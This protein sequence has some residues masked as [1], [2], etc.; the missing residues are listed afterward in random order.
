MSPKLFFQQLNA[1]TDNLIDMF[2]DDA[3]FPTFKTFVGM[4]QT[5]NPALVI[6]SYH[7][8]VGIPYKN[9]IEA[10]DES[11]ITE[12][13]PEGYDDSSVDIVTKIKG[14]WG[15]LSSNTKDSI[16]QYLHILKELAKRSQ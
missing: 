12:Y 13:N 16:W 15:V 5:T 7:T 4:L 2:P 9:Q 14:Y 1:I 8:N 3:D 10:K 11:F 6:Q